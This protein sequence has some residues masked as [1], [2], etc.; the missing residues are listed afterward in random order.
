L[1]TVYRI[2]IAGSRDFNDYTKLN[3]ESLKAIY[4]TFGKI[5]KNNVT[6]VSGHAKGADS[7]GERFAKEYSL[8]LQIFP[9]DWD[10]HGRSAGFIRNKEMATFAKGEN[11]ESSD[12]TIRGMLIAFWDGE[13]KGTKAM[14][15]L[16]KNKKMPVVVIKY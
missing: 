11:T 2:I 4:R 10:K 14:I 13:S 12:E 1:K 3:D 15:E 7:L 16:A 5:D 9:A 6:I 8:N